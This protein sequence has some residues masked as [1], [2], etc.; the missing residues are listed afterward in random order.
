MY[1]FYIQFAHRWS[2]GVVLWEIVTLGS[3][4]YPEFHNSEVLE[5]L[6]TG[7]R[8]PKPLN[9]PQYLYVP[10]SAKLVSYLKFLSM[11]GS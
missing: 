1:N 8:M 7:Y 2:F 6:R 9:C 10:F 5:K 11:H 3:L 4:P